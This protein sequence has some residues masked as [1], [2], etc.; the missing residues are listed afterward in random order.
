MSEQIFPVGENKAGPECNKTL[1]DLSLYKDFHR[2][3]W[4]KMISKGFNVLLEFVEVLLA[5]AAGAW[6]VLQCFLG[7]Q[8]LCLESLQSPA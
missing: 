7:I 6:L 3:Y 4:D 2:G 5:I 1:L 8:I